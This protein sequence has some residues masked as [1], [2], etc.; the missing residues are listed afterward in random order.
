MQSCVAVR[1]RQSKFQT[2]WW[3]KYLSFVYLFY[4][5]KRKYATSVLGDIHC[6]RLKQIKGLPCRLQ[7]H[8]TAP[9]TST[10]VWYHDAVQCQVH[11]FRNSVT[12]RVM[13]RIVGEKKNMACN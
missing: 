13:L 1:W 6:I 10:K 5:F 11:W 8:V 4:A 12:W 3:T 2:I 7:Y 9:R